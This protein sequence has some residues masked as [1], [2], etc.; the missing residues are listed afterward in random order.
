MKKTVIF[1]V[2]LG[3]MLCFAQKEASNWYFGDNAGIRFNPNGSVIELTDGQLNTVEGCTTISN[4][5]GDL[6]FYT[7]GVT[8]YNKNH[9]VMPNGFGLF[10]DPSSTQSAIVVPQPNNPNIYFIFTVDTPASNQKPFTAGFNYSVVDMSLDNG[11]GTVTQKNVNL[12]QESS[13]KVTAVLKNCLTQSIWVI[14]YAPLVTGA[15]NTFFAYEVSTTGLN[16]TP[17]ISS[18]P[19]LIEDQRGY[20]KFSPDGTKLVSANV[21]AGLFIYDFDKETGTVSNETRININFS[22][23]GVNTQLPYGV[24]FSQNNKLLY[25][26]T[27]FQ[28]T[29]EDNDIASAQY[30]AL[31]QYNLSSANISA[32]EVVIDQRA[33]Y[34]SGLQLGPNGKIYRTM[35]ALYGLGLPFLSVINTPNNLGTSCNY[36]NNSFPLSRNARQGLPPFITSFFSEKIDIINNKTS[37]TELF[38]CEGESYTLKAEVG[39][40]ANPS[41]RWEKN[42]VLLSNSTS[43]LVIT[44]PGLYT[45]FIDPNTGNCDGILEGIAYVTYNTNPEA[46]DYTLTQCDED[47]FA[48]GF[49]R[50]NL[51]QA[52]NFVTGGFPERSVKYYTDAA[53]TTEISNIESYN[54]DADNPKPVYAKVFDEQ[55]GCFDTSVLTLNVSV[56]PISD[57]EAMPLCDEIGSEDGKNTFELIDL[58]SQ[59]QSTFGLTSNITFYTTFDEVLLEKSPL[60]RVFSNTIPYQQ[61]IYARIENDNSCSRIIK[62]ILSVNKL[63]NIKNTDT[64]YYCLNKFPETVNINAA[65]IDDNPENYSYIWSTGE[66]S[67]TI[68]VNE[69]GDYTVAVTDA[70]G[71]TKNRVVSVEPSNIATI[72]NVEIKDASKYNAV[73]IIASGEGIYEYQL[74]DEDN[75]IFIDFQSS[76]VFSNIKPGFY[77]VVVKDIK[78]DCGS[79]EPLKISVIGFPKIFTPNGD[80]FND[81]WQVYGVSETFQPSTIVYIFDRYGKLLKQISPL[82]EGWNGEMNGQ[83]LPADDYWFSV[84]LQDGRIYK[85]HFSLKR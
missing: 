36:T 67:Y 32:S 51:N 39:D 3:S 82:G 85:S 45:V 1:L 81:T 11:L 30:G 15:F 44:E 79:T 77:Y 18:Q 9:N 19:A 29:R 54:F 71:C 68:G 42:G 23:D 7:D 83:K 20:L 50:F 47:G 35:N 48:G 24:E 49:T 2:F 43:S 8:V 6:L 58:T 12:L 10:G 25:I 60:I 22:H 55:T 70:N 57:F 13:E 38:L 4:A 14:T 74:L 84:Q 34:R 63:P 69:I 5:N 28:T 64:A 75:N 17:V 61:A 21:T 56:S 40:I 65:V 73:N 33:T 31:L 72:N 26:S 78:N 27:Y 37:T 76:P 53:I 52:T 80:G 66:T 46:F 59:I 16:T 62:V 41:F